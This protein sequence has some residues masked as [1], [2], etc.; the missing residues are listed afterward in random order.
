MH[1]QNVENYALFGTTTEDD[2]LRISLSE[3]FEELF[4]SGEGGARI[5]RKKKKKK[6]RERKEE[7]KK[8]K[9]QTLIKHQ[10]ITANHKIQASQDFSAFLYK[11][12]CKNLGSLKSFL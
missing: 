9:K 5:Y 7:R 1:S 6:K 8:N 10:K 11:G 2:G 4:Q 12:S 3:G